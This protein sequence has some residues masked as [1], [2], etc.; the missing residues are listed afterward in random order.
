MKTQRTKVIDKLERL[1]YKENLYQFRLV[2]LPNIIGKLIRMM[3]AVLITLNT[4]K[5]KQNYLTFLVK[6]FNLI[7]ITDNLSMLKI[8]LISSKRPLLSEMINLFEKMLKTANI[9]LRLKKK[10]DFKLF[11]RSLLLLKQILVK[12]NILFLSVQRRIF[13]L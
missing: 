12:I 3:L 5:I 9:L 7:E 1:F 11:N 4:A 6:N 2:K 13:R 10:G 8:L